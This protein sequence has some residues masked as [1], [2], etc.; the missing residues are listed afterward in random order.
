MLSTAY[1]QGYPQRFDGRE[2]ETF[3]LVFQV[4]SFK[5][6]R[7]VEIGHKENKEGRPLT[8][9][10]YPEENLL[11]TLTETDELG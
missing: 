1:T 3:G 11:L 8:R 9:V 10:E 4:W 6:V 5:M 2:T 7:Y